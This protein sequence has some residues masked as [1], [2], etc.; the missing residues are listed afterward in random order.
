MI[1]VLLISRNVLDKK[2]SGL[3]NFFP[4]IKSLAGFRQGG[5]DEKE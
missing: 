3:G 1:H 2:S 4:K 5:K